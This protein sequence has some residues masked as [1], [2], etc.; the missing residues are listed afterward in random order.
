MLGDLP[1]VCS[2]LGKSLASL[3][4]RPTPLVDVEP[5]VLSWEPRRHCVQ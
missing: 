2:A 4:S 3:Y 5:S 1:A